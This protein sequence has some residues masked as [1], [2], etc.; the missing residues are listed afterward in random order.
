MQY[1]ESLKDSSAVAAVRYRPPVT[2][3]ATTQQFRG[4]KNN[5]FRGKNRRNSWNGNHNQQGNFASQKY[6]QQNFQRQKYHPYQ[7]P[8][9]NNYQNNKGQS[10]F[11]Q[12]RRNNRRGSGRGPGR[13]P[14]RGS[15]RCQWYGKNRGEAT[16][17]Q[18]DQ[19]TYSANAINSPSCLDYV[20]AFFGTVEIPILL[21]YARGI[22]IYRVKIRANIDKILNNVV[23]II[24]FN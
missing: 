4:R 13:C 22:N 20:N 14:D 24:L 19:Q 6:Q 8:I 9:N 17:R 5:Y 21:A 11:F 15:G 18:S 1:N 10:I 2:T 23:K 7:L 12:S 3:T 16:E